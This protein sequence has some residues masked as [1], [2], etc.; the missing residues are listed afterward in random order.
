MTS[1]S[2]LDNASRVF[3]SSLSAIIVNALVYHILEIGYDSCTLFLPMLIQ[4][5]GNHVMEN[6]HGSQVAKELTWSEVKNSIQ[7]AGAPVL[8]AS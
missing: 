7:K 6:L 4:D 5:I 3:P 1:E 8:P 2:S